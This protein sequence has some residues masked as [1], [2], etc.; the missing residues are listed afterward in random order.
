MIRGEIKRCGIHEDTQ[1]PTRKNTDPHRSVKVKTDRHTRIE[2]DRSRYI[3]GDIR[4]YTRIN[5]D[6]HG[7]ECTWQ[8]K[9][10]MG[11]MHT[12]YTW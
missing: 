12:K 7:K 6:T 2:T 11:K 9:I 4:S 10:H 8:G 1:R 3:H 5:T